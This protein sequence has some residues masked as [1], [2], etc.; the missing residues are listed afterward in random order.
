MDEAN[1]PGWPCPMNWIHEQGEKCIQQGK[2]QES[3]ENRKF[4][5]C[6]DLEAATMDS[7]LNVILDPPIPLT[8][9]KNGINE[10][11]VANYSSLYNFYYYKCDFKLLFLKVTNTMKI[12]IQS[13]FSKKLKFSKLNFPFDSK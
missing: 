9:D 4:L 6:N 11:E 5:M 2:N 13:F 7:L 12:I 3:T 10:K 1:F 8:I